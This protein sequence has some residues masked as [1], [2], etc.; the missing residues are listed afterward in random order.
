M[1]IEAK[2]DLSRDG[3]ALLLTETH[4]LGNDSELSRIRSLG[5]P[6]VN[7]RVMGLM[8]TRTLGDFGLESYGIS[9]VPHMYAVCD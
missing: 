7:N 6:V 1:V 2:S 8:V 3:Q 5:V 4:S 9:S